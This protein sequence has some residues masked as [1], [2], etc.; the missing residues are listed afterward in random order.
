MKKVE[1]LM[2]HPKTKRFLVRFERFSIYDL[3]QESKSKEML[4]FLFVV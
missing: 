3:A 2:Q 1:R 4:T